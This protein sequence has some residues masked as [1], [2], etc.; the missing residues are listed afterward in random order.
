MGNLQEM[1]VDSQYPRSVFSSR[2]SDS[3][4]PPRRSNVWRPCMNFPASAL[5]GW[6]GWRCV[7]QV[8]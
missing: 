4:K 1:M 2:A 6:R 8:H 5:A 7:V 3:P